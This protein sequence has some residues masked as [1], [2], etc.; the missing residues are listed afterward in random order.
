MKDQGEQWDNDDT[1]AQAGER[2]EESAT[3]EPRPIS[4]VK[5]RTDIKDQ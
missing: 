1:A 4:A 2:A 3:K 5:S